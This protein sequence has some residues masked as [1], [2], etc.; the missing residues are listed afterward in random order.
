[1]GVLLHHLLHIQAIEM[2]TSTPTTF[3]TRIAKS[4]DYKFGALLGANSDGKRI[5][6]LNCSRE[7]VFDAI[8]EGCTSE[9]VVDSREAQYF[10]LLEDGSN[11]QPSAIFMNSVRTYEC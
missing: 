4:S 8:Y 2:M 5:R 9:I 3:T 10:T 11:F 6:I 1:M 7:Y